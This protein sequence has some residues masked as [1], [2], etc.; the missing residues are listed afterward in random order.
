MSCLPA[1]TQIPV[2]EDAASDVPPRAVTPSVR[3]GQSWL[4][5]AGLAM[6][7]ATVVLGLP[8]GRAAA[9]EA[10][11]DDDDTSAIMLSSDSGE[12]WRTVSFGPEESLQLPEGFQVNVF[13]QNLAGVRFMTIGPDGDLYA[14]LMSGGQ[15]VRLPDRDGDAEA[16]QAIA[17]ATGLRQPHG[18]AFRDGSL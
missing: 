16:G 15:I 7:L 5:T 8:A 13:A 14:S 6:V 3:V 10:A 2:A 12:A 9:T 1:T 18:L 4:L 17:V 11:I